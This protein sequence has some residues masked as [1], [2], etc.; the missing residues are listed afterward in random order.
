MSHKIGTFRRDDV[1]SSENRHFYCFMTRNVQ[2]HFAKMALAERKCATFQN[3]H[4][5]A[6]DIYDYNVFLGNVKVR[7]NLN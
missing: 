1:D 6:F 3:N 2:K 7:V 5:M 4:Q